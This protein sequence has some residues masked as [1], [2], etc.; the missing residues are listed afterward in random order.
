MDLKNTKITHRDFRMYKH[1]L[2]VMLDYRGTKRA[3][4]YDIK[5]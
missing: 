2:I 5:A 3:I 4:K 1:N